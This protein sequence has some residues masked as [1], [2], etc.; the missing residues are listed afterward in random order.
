M[1]LLLEQTSY[2]Q[3]SNQSVVNLAPGKTKG[4]LML[5]RETQETL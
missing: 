2:L 1:P 5:F 4:E 3:G